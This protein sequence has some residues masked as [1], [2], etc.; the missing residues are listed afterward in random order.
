MGKN[1]KI[2]SPCVDICEYRDSM[3]VGC[4]RTKKQKKQW[5]SADSYE[6][7]LILLRECAQS[8]Q[9]FGIF[10]FWEREY[11]RKCRKKGVPFPL[12]IALAEDV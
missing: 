3:C 6:E 1:D 11:R 4:G 9:D 12:D 5:K 2:P 10:G 7:Q 8:A